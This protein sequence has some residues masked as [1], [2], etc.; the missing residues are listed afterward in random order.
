VLLKST[1]G[2]PWRPWT[3]KVGQ[4]ALLHPCLRLL[5]RVRWRTSGPSMW[6]TQRAASPLNPAPL[7]PCLPPPP[8]A[9][10]GDFGLSMRIDPGATHISD[11]FQGTITHMVGFWGVLGA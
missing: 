1:G 11:L 4:A 6:S 7:P 3:A 5:Q 10:V 2:D 9:K 8:T